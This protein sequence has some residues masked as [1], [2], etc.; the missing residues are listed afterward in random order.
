MGAGSG[1]GGGVLGEVLGGVEEC[2]ANLS[3]K[4]EVPTVERDD[5]LRGL[6]AIPL[7]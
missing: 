5:Q 6:R 3:D 7:L 4:P 2:N 1:R